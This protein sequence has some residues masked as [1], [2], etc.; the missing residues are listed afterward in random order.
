MIVA[1]AVPE[2]GEMAR[3]GTEVPVPSNRYQS[4]S[5]LGLHPVPIVVPSPADPEGQMQAPPS[6]PPS[7]LQ[8]APATQSEQLAPSLAGV[9]LNASVP[10]PP[11]S[12]IASA[13]SSADA[14]PSVASACAS[15]SVPPV[16]A[17]PLAP[18][19]PL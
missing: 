5:G 1:V 7:A 19:A 6:A 17:A 16:P 11:S 2:G 14:S 13:A 12:T 9:S 3:L 18:A 8:V 4:S 10:V 15:A